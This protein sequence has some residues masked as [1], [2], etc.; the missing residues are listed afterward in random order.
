MRWKFTRGWPA[1]GGGR[2][3]RWGF[4]VR[5]GPG[6][7]PEPPHVVVLVGE[8][9]VRVVA[10]VLVVA[11]AT[12]E[13]SSRFAPWQR[14]A[15]AA[16]HL[17]LRAHVAR[18]SAAHLASLV[19]TDGRRV[20][21]RLWP[22]TQRSPRKSPRVRQAGKCAGRGAAERGTAKGAEARG[23]DGTPGILVARC[24]GAEAGVRAGT[25]SRLE[26]ASGPRRRDTARQPERKGGYLRLSSARGTTVRAARTLLWAVVCYT[27][28]GQNGVLWG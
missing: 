6:P 11:E 27:G 13:D 24:A 7:V 21:E 10:A 3:L 12:A 2:G 23:E 16:H 22:E 1:G 18:A 19:P 20:S 26:A 28:E 5:L 25:Q 9:A 14:A 15:E 17:L 8:E 4:K